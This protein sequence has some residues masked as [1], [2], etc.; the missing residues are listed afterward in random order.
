MKV[1]ISY[2][3]RTG[4][5]E[6]LAKAIADE[7]ASRGH[8]PEWEVIRPAVRYSWFRELVLDWPRY[9]S[10]GLSLVSASWRRRHLDT[11]HQI[12]EEIQALDHPDVSGFDLV[13][14]GGPKWAQLSYPVARYCATVQG[15]RGKRVGSFFTF[16][17]PPLKTFEIE[18]YEKSMARMLA[19]VGAAHAGNVG[20]SSAYHEAGLLPLFRLAS[21]LVFRRPVTSFTLGSEYAQKGI[22]KFCDDLIGGGV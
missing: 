4:H 8:E 18:L 13:C 19:R 16:G 14:I 20:I 10:I 6:G 1:L 15:I 11:Y 3:S 5:T 22:R 7:L 9:P 12:E 2:F 17:G 21:L